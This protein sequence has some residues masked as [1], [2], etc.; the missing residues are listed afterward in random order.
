M[1][2]A[3]TDVQGTMCALEGNMQICSAEAGICHMP[4]GPGYMAPSPRAPKPQVCLRAIWRA[5]SSGPSSR[6]AVHCTKAYVQRHMYN[7]AQRLMCGGDLDDTETY[8]QRQHAYLV[9]G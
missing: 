5:A 7:V 4:K 1:Y 3:D 8:V 6:L 9:Q 2:S